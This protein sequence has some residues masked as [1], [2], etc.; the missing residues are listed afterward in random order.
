VTIVYPE[1]AQGFWDFLC[2]RVH[3]VKVDVQQLKIPSE[4]FRGDYE[5]DPVFRQHFQDWIAT[6]W[7]EKDRRI[8]Q[9]LAAA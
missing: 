5:N 3:Q 2:G 6:L 4:M 8:G 1:G 9:L 7:A